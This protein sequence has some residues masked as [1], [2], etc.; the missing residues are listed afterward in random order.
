MPGAAPRRRRRRRPTCGSRRLVRYRAPPTRR[1]RRSCAAP[2][3]AFVRMLRVC[4]RA[5]A[6]VPMC[7]R[8]FVCSCVRTRA[9]VRVCARV[10]CVPV[11]ARARARLGVLAYVRARAKMPPPAAAGGGGIPA[12]GHRRH[13]P[14]DRGRQHHSAAA[15]RSA[16][17]WTPAPTFLPG[18]A[19]TLPPRRGTP[20]RGGPAGRTQG[21]RGPG[22][23]SP[24][25]GL[26]GGA[27]RQHRRADPPPAPVPAEDP[28]DQPG[29]VGGG[30][31]RH[32]A[33]SPPAPPGWRAS[34]KCVWVCQSGPLGLPAPST[35]VHSVAN[36]S[37]LVLRCI[38]C[39]LVVRCILN[40]EKNNQ[41]AISRDEAVKSIINLP[42]TVYKSSY[43]TRFDD[44]E[45][46]M[47]KIIQ[48]SCYV[49]IRILCDGN[50]LNFG[51]IVP[52]FMHMTLSMCN[53]AS[54]VAM[55]SA[56][57]ISTVL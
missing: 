23:A 42:S 39:S 8:A 35:H 38:R 41:N 54:S 6:C 53:A 44:I 17:P 21:G 22:G 20:A 13:A 40:L 24:A 27:S 51:S 16:G 26:G 7:S 33:D 34:C 32:R 43:F 15:F 37:S 11:C 36:V 5:C 10:F 12:P 48:A 55:A 29:G 1:R 50:G 9:R 19:R 57:L 30:S 31:A 2:I 46:I 25:V 45:F 49:V 52:G 47:F 56:S 14:A 18:P 3:A 4:V 28:E